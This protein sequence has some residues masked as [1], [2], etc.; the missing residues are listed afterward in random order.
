MA[1][2]KGAPVR[3]GLLHVPR[4]DLEMGDALRSALRRGG[5]AAIVLQEGY[6]ADAR[7]WVEETLRRWADEEELDLILTVGGT[8]PAPGPSGREIVP[9]ATLAVLERPMPGLAELMRWAVGEEVRRATLHR[10]VAGIRGRTLIVNLPAGAAA[11]RFLEAVVEE[12]EAILA[13][14]REDADAPT[15][16]DGM[17][18]TAADAPMEESPP[19]PPGGKGLNAADFAAFL[20][21]RKGEQSDREA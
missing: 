11:P 6:A 12:L 13:H 18:D 4:V 20:Q 8:L 15:L 3:V 7:H 19:A 10:G 21:R 14:L 2:M 1:G 16:A 5:L 17:V 9:E